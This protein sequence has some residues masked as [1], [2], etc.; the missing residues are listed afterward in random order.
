MPAFNA[1]LF[2][3][4]AIDSVLAQRRTDWELIVVDDGSTDTT[5][6]ILQECRRR[7][8]R[9]RILRQANQGQSAARNRGI[10]ESRG[11]LIAF[12]DADDCWDPAKL[13][14]QIPTFQDQEVGLAFTG[15]Q[16]ID[17]EGRSIRG[18]EN[19]Q[20]HR[21]WIL[22]R[23]LRNNFICCSSV[24][25]R[26]S[27][28]EQHNLRFVTGR[29]CEDW[30]LWCQVCMAAKADCVDAPLVHY[31][32]HPQG[33]SRNQRRMI[34]GEMG[35]RRDLNAM[36]Q[37]APALMGQDLLVLR[38]AARLELHKAAYHFARQAFRD[39]DLEATRKH[40]AEARRT[41]PFK[42]GR[43]WRMIRLRSSL[44]L[45]RFRGLAG[46]DGARH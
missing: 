14:L 43:I 2:I 38:H 15:V 37:S 21:G 33:T 23:L 45:H 27:L 42:L 17:A 5:P 6:Q 44:L 39:G 29:V 40:W 7:D 20:F 25:V 36:L 30:L 12:L 4:E 46:R 28:L 41:L 3:Q 1:S 24:V 32:V 9:I 13:D 18:P 22:D 19:W 26:K 16:D 35:C 11:A 8:D 31:R 10:D 34:E